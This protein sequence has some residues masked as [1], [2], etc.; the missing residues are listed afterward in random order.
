MNLVL[1]GK[2]LH[3]P[4][5]ILQL[6]RNT[7]SNKLIATLVSNVNLVF[8]PF[9]DRQILVFQFE[10]ARCEHTLNSNVYVE[11][12]CNQLSPE[13]TTSG[14]YNKSAFYCILVL[15]SPIICFLHLTFISI[16]A[17]A[18][19]FFILWAYKREECVSVLRSG[20]TSLLKEIL[21]FMFSLIIAVS[22]VWADYFSI[23]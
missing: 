3:S 1:L 8:K 14:I 7:Q 16:I 23:L 15:C 12:L 19:I 13:E 10:L 6:H 17:Y 18:D 5:H 11:V 22:R 21:D 20:I 4:I 2:R 9:M